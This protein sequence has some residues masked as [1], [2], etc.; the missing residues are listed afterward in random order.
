M[1]DVNLPVFVSNKSFNM[2]QDIF[3]ELSNNL[4]DPVV[5][6]YTFNDVTYAGYSQPIPSTATQFDEVDFY[7]IILEDK[8]VLLQDQNEILA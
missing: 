7:I 3:S 5:V 1:P 2:T 4:F 8:D 6:E